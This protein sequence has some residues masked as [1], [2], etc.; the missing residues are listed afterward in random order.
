MTD[1]TIWKETL[2]MT[3]VQDVSLPVGAEIL[4]V[5]VQGETIAVWFRC[6]PY[7]IIREKRTF[8]ICGTGHS[9]PD[10]QSAKYL[11][12]V[13]MQGGM[14]VWHVFVRNL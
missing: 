9:T 3:N 13:L 7:E 10:P 1:Y 12:T 6:S 14:Y 2:Q 8:V 5:A 4:S 11:G